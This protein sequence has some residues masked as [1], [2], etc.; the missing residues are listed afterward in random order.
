MRC[1]RS[2]TIAATFAAQPVAGSVDVIVDFDHDGNLSTIEDLVVAS[3]DTVSVGLRVHEPV[4]LEEPIEICF[5]PEGTWCIDHYIEPPQRY[6]GVRVT[7]VTCHG[8]IVE[9]CEFIQTTR[10]RSHYWLVCVQLASGVFLTPDVV[11]E[12]FRAA[13]YPAS[14]VEDCGI[15]PDRAVYFDATWWP[16]GKKV[17]SNT[18]V[19]REPPVP[20]LE[21]TW[22]RVKATYRTHGER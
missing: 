5:Y 12:L 19:I 8:P 2:V 13:V 17:T 9:S 3:E 20:T 10:V 18:V 15:D 11:H 4:M 22:G 6:L 14:S 16:S 21:V 7:D 1:W